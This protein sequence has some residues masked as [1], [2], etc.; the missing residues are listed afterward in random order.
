MLTAVSPGL[1]LFYL[2]E[3]FLRG[4]LL[5]ALSVHFSPRGF[6]RMEKILAGSRK[7]VGETGFSKKISEKLA[8]KLV[9]V[10]TGKGTVAYKGNRFG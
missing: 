7:T 1:T 10:P 5:P 8:I 3:S 2:R 9:T 6:Y 4:I